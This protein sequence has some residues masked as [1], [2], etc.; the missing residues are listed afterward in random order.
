MLVSILIPTYDRPVFLAEAI[1]A[2]LASTWFDLEVIVGDNGSA[3][4]DVCR[5]FPDPRLRYVRNSR[6]LGMAG[7]WSA[8]LDAARGEYVALCSDDDK[9]APEFVERCLA[10]FE[11]DPEVGVVFTNHDFVSELGR[12]T[13][14]CGLAPGRH[15]DFASAFL[16]WR[17]VAASAALFRREAWQIARPLPDTSAADM[18]LFGRIAEARLPFFYLAESLMDY[19]THD[20][21]LS[22]TPGFK[23]DAVLAWATLRFSDVKA[24]DRRRQLLGDAL[25]SRAK[26]H[27]RVGAELEARRDARRA[28]RLLS[29]ARRAEAGAVAALSLVPAVA[30]SVAHVVRMLRDRRSITR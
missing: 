12:R 1:T 16:E 9:L 15:D 5:R 21:M 19:R 14:T 7:N 25:L 6:D 13:R 11:D 17:P 3:G 10:V 26:L 29:G 23:D 2:A 22:S 20:E 28:A 8:M 4:G 18:V 24:E 30:P 27:V